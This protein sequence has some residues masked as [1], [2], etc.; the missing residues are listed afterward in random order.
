MSLET[1]D[2]S[3]IEA[4]LFDVG[5][6]FFI[7]SHVVLRPLLTDLAVVAPDDHTFRRAHYMGIRHCEE[8]LEDDSFWTGY[9]A[10]YVE[11]LGID[12]ADRARVVEAIHGVWLSGMRLW[13]WIQDDAVAALGRIAKLRRVGIVSNAD[14]TVERDLGLLGVCQI[15]EGEGTN[16]EVIVD[17]TVVGVSKPNPEIFRFALEPMKL[18]ADQCL[19]VGDAYRYDVIGATRAGLQAVHYDPY[20]L[21][22]GAG[23]ARARTL[24]QLADLLEAFTAER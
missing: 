10:R 23:H 15:G 9:N 18:R 21:H 4:V 2:V 19:Y 24:D 12:D 22:E 17:S 5:G 8:E 11:S 3:R 6:V 13:T 16:V 1:L 14:G 20:E 7:P